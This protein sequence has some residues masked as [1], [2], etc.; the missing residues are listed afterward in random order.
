MYAEAYNRYTALLQN[1]LLPTPPIT[2]WQAGCIFDTVL[3][4]LALCTNGTID[5]NGGTQITLAEAQETVTSVL[6]KYNFDVIANNANTQ[7]VYANVYY[8]GTAYTGNYRYYANWY[9]DAGWWGIACAKAFDPYYQSLFTDSSLTKAQ[10]IAKACWKAMKEGT[11]DEYGGA[12][13]VYQNAKK[14]QNPS[15]SQTIPRYTG[16]VWQADFGDPLTSSLGPFQDSVVNGLWLTLS[17][18]LY[19]KCNDENLKTEIAPYIASTIRFFENWVND[20]EYSILYRPTS[21][22]ALLRE[23]TPAYSNEVTQHDGNILVN[24][25]SWYQANTCW[26]GD[27]GLFLGGLYEYSTLPEPDKKFSDGYMPI[28]LNGIATIMVNNTPSYGNILSPWYPIQDNPLESTDAADYASGVGVCARYLLYGYLKGPNPINYALSNS[29]SPLHSV[30]ANSAKCCV[31][32]KFPT[33]GNTAF[34]HFN[35]LSILILAMA[36][37][38]N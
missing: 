34:D 31:D 7:N 30:I 18:R 32:H 27:Q 24:P 10:G 22:Q 19:G 28:I 4:F 38:V 2:Y 6:N 13:N 25:A 9:D 8:N 1:H 20:K 16:G 5:T 12:P 33:Y 3:D 37:K 23:R 26:G 15:V 35:N 14:N 36:M 11:Y 21:V 17:T 29:T